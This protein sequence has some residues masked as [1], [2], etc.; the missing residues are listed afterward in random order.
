MNLFKSDQV[1]SAAVMDSDNEELED[2]PQRRTTRKMAKGKG[3][4][5]CLGLCFS[6]CLLT[7]AVMVGLAFLLK[8]EE[9]P[10]ID[11]QVREVSLHVV[12][13]NESVHITKALVTGLCL[14]NIVNCE[15]YFCPI[16]RAW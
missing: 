11:S 4:P 3:M 16:Y 7:C 14:C 1:V 12:L 13:F 9:E 15:M 2:F 5:I 10:L 6:C 8:V